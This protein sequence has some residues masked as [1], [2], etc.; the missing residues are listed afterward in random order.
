MANKEN[1]KTTIFV[2]IGIAAVAVIALVIAGKILVSEIFLNQKVLSKKTATRDQMDANVKAAPELVANYNALGPK[3]DLILRS[4]PTSPDFKDFI[5]AMES[6]GN[7]SGAR[8]TSVTPAT[9]EAPSTSSK[10]ASTA[11]YTVSVDTG[12]QGLFTMLANIET[13]AWPMR[14]SA[15]TA[16]SGGANLRADLTIHSYYQPAASIELGKEEVK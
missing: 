5:A 7:S 1:N 3:A 11:V 15:M 14:V 4:L 13:S 8:I 12:Y 10:G 2:A 16:N 9:A 6:I